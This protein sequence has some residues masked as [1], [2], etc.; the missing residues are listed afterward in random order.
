M[1]TLILALAGAATLAAALPALA[2]PD[3]TVIERAR[4]EKRAAQRAALQQA[5]CGQG[6]TA[7]APARAG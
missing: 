5:S 2:G 4:A 3:W 1:K 7:P 6:A